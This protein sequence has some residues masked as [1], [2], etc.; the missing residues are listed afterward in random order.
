MLVAFKLIRSFASS[1][2]PTSKLLCFINFFYRWWALA[3]HSRDSQIRDFAWPKY[4]FSGIEWSLTNI[5]MLAFFPPF[6]PAEINQ[7]FLSSVVPFPAF[8]TLISLAS[9]LSLRRTALRTLWKFSMNSLHVSIDWLRWVVFVCMGKRNY[10]MWRPKASGTSQID[11]RNEKV[12]CCAVLTFR[13]NFGPRRIL[14]SRLSPRWRRCFAPKRA[15]SAENQ[16]ECCR[17]FRILISSLFAYTAQTSE[18]VK[19]NRIR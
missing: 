10:S 3:N 12:S 16:T 1:P 7:D 6:F 18:R 8:C 9:L 19:Q 5:L 2:C 11:K 13:H 15:K 14:S 4:I 17:W